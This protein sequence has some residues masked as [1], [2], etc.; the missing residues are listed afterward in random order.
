MIPDR[1]VINGFATWKKL[2]D[3]GKD[4]IKTILSFTWFIQYANRYILHWGIISMDKLMERTKGSIIR[5][6]D[7]TSAKLTCIKF[8]L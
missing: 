3:S 7:V 6:Q 1:V 8:G 4:Y 2:C 5:N